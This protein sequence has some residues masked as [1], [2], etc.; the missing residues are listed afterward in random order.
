[1]H[2][3]QSQ[4]IQDRHKEFLTQRWVGRQHQCGRSL[5]G[6][7]RKSKF[8][9]RIIL[10][11]MKRT[12][13]ALSILCFSSAALPCSRAPSNLYRG[14]AKIVNE[15]N[16]ILLVEAIATPEA[17]ESSCQFRVVRTLK[18]YVPEEI[19][20]TCR[21]PNHVEKTFDFDSHSSAIFWQEYL[22][23]GR[24]Y[25]STNCMLMPPFFEPGHRYVLLLGIAPDTKQFEEIKSDDDKWLNFI[26]RQLSLGKL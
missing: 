25:V 2:Q 20:V 10:S 6:Q 15:A 17:Q 1:M 9:A 22:P 3:T 16:V 12:V 23:H 19:P 8:Y 4:C 5:H 13:I 21:L 18:G 24:L 11:I 14:H 7:K 26:E